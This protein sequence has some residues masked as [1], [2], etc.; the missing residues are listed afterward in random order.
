M[1]EHHTNFELLYNTYASMVYN[2]ALQYTI[3]A[4]DAEDI[5]Q[6]VFIKINEKLNTFNS[7]KAS[8]KTWIYQIA[9]NKSLDFLKHKQAKKRKGVWVNIDEDNASSKQVSDNTH[10]GIV[11]EKKEELT[12]LLNYIK[13][14]PQNQQTALL[15][16]YYEMLPQAEIAAIM[17]CSIKA[18]DG[19]LARAKQNLKAAYTQQYGNKGL[20]MLTIALGL[21]YFIYLNQE[22][23]I[24]NRTNR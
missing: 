1:V 5:T 10:P 20:N 14:L 11:A 22:E 16:K 15:L 23:L 19:L 12:E 17:Q 4:H 21:L 6:E 18:V 8:L 24:Y 9:I 13:T 7:Q 2:L 3:N